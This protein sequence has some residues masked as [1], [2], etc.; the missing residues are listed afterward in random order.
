MNE[1]VRNLQNYNLKVRRVNDSKKFLKLTLLALQV[2]DCLYL[3]FT[4]T[5]RKNRWQKI[6]MLSKI[7]RAMIMAL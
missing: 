5:S 7:N 3:E 1:V 4:Y 6:F 2:I